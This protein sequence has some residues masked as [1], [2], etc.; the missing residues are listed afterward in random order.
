MI[1][2]ARVLN[3]QV[4]L[5]QS[6]FDSSATVIYPL[7]DPAKADSSF[8]EIDSSGGTWIAE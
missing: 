8:S 1:F 5:T 4:S 3:I 7:G 6:S 2:Y